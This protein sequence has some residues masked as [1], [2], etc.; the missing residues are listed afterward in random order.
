VAVLSRI[1][2]TNPGAMAE[3]RAADLE[4]V[5]DLEGYEALSGDRVAWLRVLAD[6]DGLVVGLQ[7]LSAESFGVA[8]SLRYVLRIGTGLD[9][10]DLVAAAAHGVMVESLPGL[11]A[12]AVAEYAFGLMLAAARRIPE[13]DRSMRA[14][15]WARFPGR[16][17]AGRTLGLIGYGQ[18]ARLMVPKAR[19]FDMDV[20]VFRRSPD[21]IGHDGVRQVEFDELLRQSDFIS[22]HVPLTE[23]TRSLIGRREFGLMRDGVVLVNTA[24]GAVVDEQE[25]HRALIGGKVAACALDVFESEPPGRSP[26]LELPNVV[27][28]PHNG[29][30]SDVITELTALTAAR[31]LIAGVS[32]SARRATAADAPAVRAQ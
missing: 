13:A 22:V 25:L 26:L 9:N 11:N 2:G 32:P 21:P 19:G 17:L 4:V 7:P 14:G 15:E 23:Q 3:L 1:L 30:Y 12:P 28:S 20:L 29:G 10:I 27:A 8:P 16:H 24:R 6:I 31:R 5:L 18:I